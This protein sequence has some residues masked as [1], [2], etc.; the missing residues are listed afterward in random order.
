MAKNTLVA[1]G[2]SGQSAAIAYLR[3]ATLSGMPPEELPNIYVI[4]ADVKDRQGADAKP[5]LYSSLKVLFTQLVQGVAATNKPRLELIYPYSHQSHDMMSNS[6]VFADYI[7]N[8]GGVKQDMAL[9]TDALFSKKIGRGND[10]VLSEQDVPLSKGFMARPNVGATTFFDKLHQGHGILEGAISRLQDAVANGHNQAVTVVVGSSF[11]GTG[12]GV[13]PSLA[14]QMAEWATR[15]GQRTRIGLFM[16]L[17][18][19]NP[20]GQKTQP[21]AVPTHG[22]TE[23]QKKNTAGG[24]RYYATSDAFRLF[25][26]FIADYAGHMQIRNDDSNSEQPEYEHV[27]NILLASQI[28]NYFIKKTHD[29]EFINQAGAYTFY[30]PKQVGSLGLQFD[31]SNSAL[32]SY[33]VNRDLKQDLKNWAH[34]AQ[35]LR[36][37]LRHTAR[38]IKNEFKLSTSSEREVPSEFAALALDIAQKDGRPSMVVIKSK[39]NPFG[40]DK[41]AHE[42]YVQIAQ[43]L[44]EREKQLGASIAWL[45]ALSNN[46]NELNIDEASI[47]DNPDTLF[48]QYKALARD[49]NLEVASVRL[50][51]DA[52]NKKDQNYLSTFENKLANGQSSLDAVAVVIEEAIR[53]EIRKDSAVPRTQDE[54]HTATENSG[55]LNTVFIPMQVGHNGHIVNSYWQ[56]IDLQ[57]LVDDGKNR[58]D[59]PLTVQDPKHPASLSGLSHFSIPSPW[60]AAILEQ[61]NQKAAVQASKAG[62]LALLDR[63]AERLE[64]ILWAIF[65]KKLL[66]KTIRADQVGSIAHTAV[67][68]RDI[69]IQ[70]NANNSITVAINPLNQQLVAANYPTVGWFATPSIQGVL[71]DWW[72]DDNELFMR[73]PT[74]TAATTRADS[75]DAK[76][77]KSFHLWLKQM[78]DEHGESGRAMS[79]YE[80][81]RHTYHKLSAHI[82]EETVTLSLPET[83][84]SFL[85]QLPNRQIITVPMVQVRESINEIIENAC[86]SQLIVL[87]NEMLDGQFTHQ[88]PDSPL[89]T[90]VKGTARRIAASGVM[91]ERNGSGS[92]I[93]LTY[94]LDL[95]EGKFEVTRKGRIEF[96]RVQQVVWPN[97][98]AD[99]WNLYFA[100]G[101]ATNNATLINQ[102]QPDYAYR[103]YSLLDDGTY[104]EVQYSDGHNAELHHF[105]EPLFFDRNY[106]LFGRP[107]VLVMLEKDQTTQT[108]QE[109]GSI[110]VNLKSTD[111][112]D[113]LQFK[114]GLDFGTSHSCV[115]ALDRSDRKISF[116]DFTRSTEQTSLLQHV[117]KTPR[118]DD[119]LLDE[120]RF[121]APFAAKMQTKELDK[122][123]LPTEFRFNQ[124]LSPAKPSQELHAGIRYLTILPMQFQKELAERSIK[125]T[126]ALGDFKWGASSKI[127][128]LTNTSYEGKEL[129]LSQQYIKQILRIALAMLRMKGYTKLVSFRATYPEAF[130]TAN[131]NIFANTLEDIWKQLLV[132]TGLECDR[133]I[134]TSSLLKLKDFSQGT[135]VTGGQDLSVVSHGL[136]SESI[137]ALQTTLK[138]S[139]RNLLSDKTLQIVLDMGG[140][141]TD[142]AAFL[143]T[144]ALRTELPKQLPTSLTDSIRYA[145]HDI[146]SLL[147]NAEVARVLDE[148]IKLDGS[149]DLQQFMRVIKIA[150]RDTKA[151]RRL[152]AKFA[153]GNF[154][155]KVRANVRAFFDGLFEYARQL[156]ESYQVQLKELGIENLTVGIV[157]LGN[158]WRLGNLVYTAE[159]VETDI[160]GLIHEMQEYMNKNLEGVSSLN[161]V[162]PSSSDISVK[163]SIAYGALLYNV[164]EED[165]RNT[166]ETALA[167]NRYSFIGSA[168]LTN[169]E[170]NFVTQQKANDRRN[171]SALQIEELP[172]FP[173]NTDFVARL[174]NVK[175]QEDKGLHFAKLDMNKQLNNRWRSAEDEIMISPMQLF[176]E[177]VWK[178]TLL[179]DK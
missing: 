59:E 64:A 127:S 147:S 157:L 72:D 135:D 136:I 39:W 158:G 107:D 102:A 24:L 49:R 132:E 14:Q 32:L 44:E 81:M 162:F 86:C 109:V 35:A 38:F 89:K 146:L 8:K 161:I 141:S 134:T 168:K 47:Q 67:R 46:C 178:P 126:G 50:F 16:T 17:P 13:A 173:T 33:A 165:V 15:S 12:S 27:F 1:V 10:H 87:E 105:K 179:N 92:Y 74:E 140:G 69:E 53:Q 41:A 112:T 90:T 138:T 104:Q 144:T 26:V 91:N 106:E 5:S 19:F 45:K 142:V 150:M 117:I 20:N 57:A 66:V 139:D 148:N 80:A 3:M 22:S 125:D 145:G 118:G 77:I 174:D 79:W 29:S 123:V 51:E 155:L 131:I 9:V 68:V 56:K 100:A 110:C 99:K 83:A 163:E 175:G 43:K 85:L 54:Q 84:E 88:Y 103:L 42:I 93:N 154:A 73:L 115:V 124:W 160:N 21:D 18:W 130:N 75:Y 58:Q 169:L 108:Y 176:L 34:E 37:A 40:K 121:I 2:G 94:E 60:G 48:S 133:G 172:I 137:G 25:D 164:E 116:L 97:F 30:A 170:G 119:I 76:L 159:N 153:E 177:Y 111:S 129:E 101:T 98:K 95:P 52:L 171:Q 122:N 63:S 166:G 11:G 65:N 61:W 120:F 96:L 23:I 70:A 156:I 28:Q 152:Q 167:R 4:D 82:S 149:N 36:L 7:I 55:T 62:N 128:S 78:L 113:H 31:A 114:L 143:N 71:R 6:T 151:V